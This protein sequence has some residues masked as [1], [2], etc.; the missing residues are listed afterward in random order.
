VQP[1]SPSRRTALVLTGT[2]AHGAYHA[3]VL[4]ALQEAGVK[5]DLVAG[6]GVGVGGAALAAIDGATRLWDAEGI[7]RSREVRR[8]YR[9]RWPLR[10]VAWLGVVLAAILL[11]PVAVLVAGLLVYL[12]GFL[13]EMLQVEAGRALVSG[14]SAWLQAAFSGGGLP[15]SV[16]R[17]A[18][19]VLIALVVVLAIGGVAAVRSIGSRRVERRWW[20]RIIA[21]P[22]EAH[23][24]RDRFVD[25]IWAAIR[26][27]APVARPSVAA[28]GRRYVE[29]LSENLGQP[30]FRELVVVATDLDARRDVVAAL[31][32]EP[33]RQGFLTARPGR[34]R[35]AEVLDL[36]GVARDHVIDVL[37]AGLTPPILCDPHLMT[38]APDSF[39]RGETHR[40]CDRAGAVARLLEE[41]AEAGAT[42]VIIVTAVA[43]AA[44]PHR[45]RVPR[46]DVAGRF[47]EFQTASESAALRDAL[48]AIGPRFDAVYVIQPGHNAI[49]PFDMNGAYDEASDRRQD[50]SELMERGYEDAYRQFIEPV[51][52]ASGDQLAHASVG[53]R[54]GRDGR[55]PDDINHH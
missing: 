3:G 34:D 21:A 35:R 41:V 27:A 23:A 45:L 10:A 25:A 29:V 11:T 50:L 17:L 33:Y 13:L 28:L 47:A 36:T 22:L 16:P 48:V 14:Y 49:G 4:R 9:W 55:G 15:T 1:Y 18:V 40:L 43:P 8:L 12:V 39:W 53:V 46:A 30:G 38:F 19:I 44:T 2:G 32:A 54:D 5:I 37:G 31:L 24:A 20:W 51:V 42:Q 6:Q 26:G 7:W 52:G